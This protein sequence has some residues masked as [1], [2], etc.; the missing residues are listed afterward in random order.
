MPNRKEYWKF[1]D[2]TAEKGSISI[3]V[4]VSGYFF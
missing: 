3:K 1:L 2:Q 4:T